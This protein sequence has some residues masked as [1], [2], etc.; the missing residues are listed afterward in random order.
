MRRIEYT[1]RYFDLVHDSCGC[2]S[3]MEQQEESYPTMKDAREEALWILEYNDYVTE[4]DI[5]GPNNSLITLT[6]D[7]VER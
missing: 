2:C 7:D 5:L 3:H 6:E 4:V 1:I